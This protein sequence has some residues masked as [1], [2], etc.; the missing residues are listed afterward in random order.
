MKHLKTYKI[1]ESVDEY[2]I[3]SIKDILFSISEC[4]FNS[5]VIPDY[6]AN[7]YFGRQSWRKKS[8][9]LFFWADGFQ[10]TDKSFLHGLY[11][12][13]DK[14]PKMFGCNIHY[15]LFSD[16]F[17]FL[18]LLTNK[19][20]PL[21]KRFVRKVFEDDYE[22]TLKIKDTISKD[23]TPDYFSAKLSSGIKYRN[24][25]SSNLSLFDWEYKDMEIK[26]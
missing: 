21:S 13:K 3:Q 1:F 11:F 15:V 8:D 17:I 5:K 2:D 23:I 20:V 24:G 9:I 22:I 26:F 7:Q 16:D 25:D 12:Y 10:N 4:D 19:D 6:D 18:I 14:F